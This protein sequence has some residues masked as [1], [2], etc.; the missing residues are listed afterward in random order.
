MDRTLE[1]LKQVSTATISTQLLARGLR[2]TFLHGLKPLNKE[3]M[4]GPAFTLRYI[5]AREDIDTLDVFKDYD[6]PQRKAIEDIPEGHVLVM[7]CRGQGRAA[8]AGGIL[9]TR[10]HI[11][12]A[13]G[14]V[15]DG[16]LR[17]TPEIARLD[18]PAYARGPSPLT[19][20]AQHH[21]TDINVPIGCAEVPVYPGDIMVGDEE[22]VVCIPRHLAHEIAEAAH[23]QE[24]L[25]RFIQ[26]EIASGK[27]LKGTYPP[28]EETLK[29]YR[30]RQATRTVGG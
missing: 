7:D 9:A 18:M 6:H 10:L 30:A 21:A 22:G 23:Q 24:D 20:L 13:A 8:S 11:R 15:T 16:A 17:D 2:N 29:R 25:E 19:N 4:A 26:Q 3:R 12:N 27:P 1:L 5:P 28:D 14:L